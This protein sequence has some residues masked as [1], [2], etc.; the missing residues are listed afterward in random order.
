MRSPEQGDEFD[1]AGCHAHATEDASVM[2]R[3]EG[4]GMLTFTYV[5][6]LG[7]ALDASTPALRSRL[8]A[9]MR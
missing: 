9:L 1:I 3:A 7:V 4:V 2:I 8:K 5:A 6:A